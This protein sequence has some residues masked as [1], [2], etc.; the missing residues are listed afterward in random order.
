MKRQTRTTNPSLWGRVYKSMIKPVITWGVITVTT[1]GPL[2]VGTNTAIAE[3]TKPNADSKP[4]TNI[5]SKT[6]WGKYFPFP[7]KLETEIESKYQPGD[8]DSSRFGFALTEIDKDGKPVFG[9]VA[10]VFTGKLPDGTT[11]TNAGVRVPFDFGYKGKLTLYGLEHEDDEGFGARL[12]GSYG[13]WL[14]KGVMERLKLYSIEEGKDEQDLKGLG[15]GRI[16]R[17]NL[18]ETTLEF[19]GY[20]KNDKTFGNLFLFQDFPDGYSGGLSFTGG[21]KDNRDLSASFGR[22]KDKKSWRLHGGTAMDG[23]RFSLGGSFIIDPDPRF[24]TIPI[25]YLSTDN[26]V[27]SYQTLWDNAMGYYP[28]QR[29]F[30]KG[31]LVLHADYFRNEDSERVLTQASVRPFASNSSVPELIRRIHIDGRYDLTR[32]EGS[33]DD[34]RL[35]GGIGIDVYKDLN[36]YFEKTEGESP[37]IGLQWKWLRY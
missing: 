25:G 22:F 10:R 31:K 8:T 24:A 32:S 4:K 14:L 13:D 2:S 28:Y 29:L 6:D 23:E 36:L 9:D 34:D 12:S 15:I 7:R 3:E 33:G 11:K 18:G 20:D 16:F 26:G 21:D 35:T 1:L 30:E 27:K 37:V 19:W 5:V 17:S